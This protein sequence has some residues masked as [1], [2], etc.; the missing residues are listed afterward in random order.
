MFKYNYFLNVEDGECVWYWDNGKP[1][2]IGNYKNG[3]KEGPWKHYNT[4]G[5][6]TKTVIF[7]EGKKL[8]KIR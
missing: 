6:L 8:E 5:T 2:I 7:I 4:D 3:V 1:W